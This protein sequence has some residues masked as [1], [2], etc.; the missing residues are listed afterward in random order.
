MVTGS[1]ADLLAA[2]EILAALSHVVP[3]DHGQ[4]WEGHNKNDV[5]RLAEKVVP[6]WFLVN[7][8]YRTRT[9][10]R[11]EKVYIGVKLEKRDQAEGSR[12]FT[13]I[14]P[15]CMELSGLNK[16]CG[17]YSP[18][19]DGR[20]GG[21]TIGRFMFLCP[22]CG[23]GRSSTYSGVNGLHVG[24]ARVAPWQDD[25]FGA[26]AAE[27]AL[28]CEN[29]H[30]ITLVVSN[31]KGISFAHWRPGCEWATQDLCNI[32]GG[33]PWWPQ[34]CCDSCGNLVYAKWDADLNIPRAVC[35]ECRD[36]QD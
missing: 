2:G 21:G 1:D 30:E 3:P 33:T 22:E 7:T 6:F 18:E 28:F 19:Y 13:Y 10:G 8:V 32:Q 16:Y 27:I 9:A 26:A 35:H 24:A 31:R 23:E 29:G 25:G 4:K 15:P 20:F 34:V 36:T 12:Y 5:M 11:P 14:D 17:P